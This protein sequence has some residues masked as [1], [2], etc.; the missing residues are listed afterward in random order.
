M[1]VQTK[2]RVVS[3]KVNP[4]AVVRKG[5]RGFSTTIICVME[6]GSER[7]H[8]ISTTLKRDL[9]KKLAKLP[10]ENVKGMEMEQRDGWSS[11]TI[12]LFGYNGV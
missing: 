7:V 11:F 6:D 8:Q 4:A 2:M 3:Q 9:A 12:E 1:T 5:T 10:V